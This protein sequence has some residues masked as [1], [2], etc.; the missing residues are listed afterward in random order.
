VVL[1]EAPVGDPVSRAVNIV[2]M[3]LI[4]LSV[5]S[6]V[7]ETVKAVSA[8]HARFFRTVEVVTVLVFTVEYALRLWVCTLD[9]RFA[10][11]VKGRLRFALTPFALVDLAAI[12]PFYL[13]IVMKLDLRFLRAVRL[14][15]LFRL[16]KLGRY[17]TSLQTLG[18]VFMRKKE[19][20]LITLFIVSILIVL[21][22]SL[23]YFVEY[24]PEGGA[25]SSIPMAMWWAVV[26]LTTVGYG[27]IYPVTVLGRVLGAVVAVMGI[28]LFALPTGILG[29]A[30]VEE[31][32]KKRG[33]RQ[34]CPHCGKAIE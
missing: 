22:S 24:T 23:M 33:L 30:F 17:S 12:L 15:R 31:L 25:F 1:H 2:I 8:T 20:M 10:H 21:A 5:V 28:G 3:T 18:A 4:F 29:S 19:E 27:D 14:F 16:F 6:V 9:A 11:P 13:P 32:Q 7:L 34:V 26:T